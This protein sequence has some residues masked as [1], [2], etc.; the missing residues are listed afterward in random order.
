MKTTQ[1][2]IRPVL[3]TLAVIFISLQAFSQTYTGIRIDVV[4]ATTSDQM[5]VFATPGT[6]RGF[7][8]GWDGYKM[9]GTVATQIY[10]VEAAGNFQVDAVP[11]MNDTYIAFQAGYDTQ[12]TITVT[13]Q[14]LSA[15]YTGL[16]LIDSITNAKVDIYNT[17]SKYTF[18]ATN[19][20]PV[21]RFKLMAVTTPPPTNTSSASSLTGFT[22]VLGTGSSAVQAFAVT[23]ANLTGNIVVT[24]PADYE[25]SLASTTGFTSSAISI[26][27]I[28]GTVAA[29]NLY[30]RLKSGLAVNTYS[31]NLSITAPNV[32]TNNVTL[33]GT[34]TAPPVVVHKITITNSAKTV[35]VKNTDK[36]KGTL[37]IYLASTGKLQKTYSFNAN[38]TTSF[39]TGLKAGTYIA[40][41]V[42][43]T[44]NVSTTIII[45]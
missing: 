2:K 12:Y 13:A 18:T 1:P 21:R 40:T 39:S 8:N 36:V 14:A 5:W 9:T 29:T 34:V 35:T 30:V 24:P 11:D 38:S 16:Y 41:G 3:V 42:T 32:A 4:G 15:Y 27:P 6:T 25:I 43:A 26:A 7:D 28:S 44:D 23:G 45:Q 22:Y 20:T 33:T 31:E 10:A 19:S 37:S 17:G